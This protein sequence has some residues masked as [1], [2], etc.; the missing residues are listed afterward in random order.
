MAFL[1]VFKLLF[2]IFKRTLSAS[3]DEYYS[4]RYISGTL[5]VTKI[6]VTIRI[7]PDRWTGNVYDGT[8]KQTGFTNPGKGIADYIMIS[9]DDYADEYLD[10]VWDAAKGKLKG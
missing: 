10:D 1:L 6:N 3:F 9:H 4:I 2:S 8:E 5:E 7:E